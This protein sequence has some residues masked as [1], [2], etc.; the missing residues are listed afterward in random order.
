M[1]IIQ[2]KCTPKLPTK[3][4]YI[5]TEEYQNAWNLGLLCKE[6][7]S[8][9]KPPSRNG[10]LKGTSHSGD[11]QAGVTSM[12]IPT[13]QVPGLWQLVDFSVHASIPQTSPSPHQLLPHPITQ[14]LPWDI[15]GSSHPHRMCQGS[16]R[17]DRAVPV[18]FI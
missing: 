15:T 7:A 6:E 11:V 5:L 8:F 3:R 9:S 1:H 17:K 2:L 13:P 12:V 10:G 16:L 4:N 14:R 18:H